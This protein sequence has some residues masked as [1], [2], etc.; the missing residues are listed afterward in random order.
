MA[1]AGYGALT[2]VIGYLAAIVAAG[3]ILGV[4][5]LVR[6]LTLGGLSK[7]VFGLG[8]SSLALVVTIFTLLVTYGSKLVVAYIAGEWIM[9]KVAPEAKGKSYWAMVIGVVL[10]VILAAIPYIGWLVAL[11]ATIIG[12]GS[13]WLVYRS[14]RKSRQKLVEVSG[15]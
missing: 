10:Y 14:W 2:I 1:S 6:V 5:L 9:N 13:M 8:F 15:A 4:G 3:V 12:I 7:I 11:V